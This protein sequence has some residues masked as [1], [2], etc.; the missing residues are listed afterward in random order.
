MDSIIGNS[1]DSNRSIRFNWNC[2]KKNKTRI[3]HVRYRYTQCTFRKYIVGNLNLKRRNNKLLKHKTH[4]TSQTE[5]KKKESV[6]LPKSFCYFERKKN[7]ISQN[8][9]IGI[10]VFVPLT[11][12]ECH[13]RYMGN[14]RLFRVW[15]WKN[16]GGGR[17]ISVVKDISFNILR[18]RKRKYRCIW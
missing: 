2:G 7:C 5:D 17:S 14:I 13:I 4:R 8:I 11:R 16:V 3:K 10:N 1:Q 12:I 15:V 18:S 6:S 9:N